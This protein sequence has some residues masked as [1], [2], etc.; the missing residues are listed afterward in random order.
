MARANSV[1]L[2]AGTTEGV[3]SPIKWLL[4]RTSGERPTKLEEYS[5]DRMTLNCL[6]CGSKPAQSWVLNHTI[7]RSGPGSQSC[8]A[9]GRGCNWAASGPPELQS[10]SCSTTRSIFFAER[11][12]CSYTRAE[13]FC[14]PLHGCA[15][16]GSV[17]LFSLWC[18]RASSLATL[19]E[20]QASASELSSEQACS[21]FCQQHGAS[22]IPLALLTQT[23]TSDARTLLLQL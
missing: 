10:C 17:S 21:G 7:A 23:P 9:V 15:R 5:K 1:L 11:L 12:V 22:S 2:F 20:G 4:Q 16:G 18:G 8:S 3:H 6:I 19:E 14:K 13:P